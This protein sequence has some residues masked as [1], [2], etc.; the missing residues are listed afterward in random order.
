MNISAFWQAEGQEHKEVADKTFTALE[1][2]F[3]TWLK[4]GVSC[5]KDGGKI[6]F[7][8]NGGSAAD[9]QHLATE[10][11]VRYKTDR[12]AIAAV[13]LTTDT[14]ALS[15]IG[16]DFGFEHLFAR[17]VE[18]IGRKG[19]MLIGI[20]TSGNSANVIKAFEQARDMGITTV[21]LT[22]ETGGRIGP[23]SDMMIKIPSRT[24]ARIQEMH[25]T[26][27]QMF[28]GGLEQSL[29]RVSE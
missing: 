19:D 3:T 11:A 26:L 15:A 7:C 9:S 4:A 28:C 8:G 20:T 2:D 27:G 21:A 17:Q 29:G 24:T 12:K 6:M 23:H 1:A 18:A 10:L 22:G 14:S 13:A 5:I 16:N 25:I